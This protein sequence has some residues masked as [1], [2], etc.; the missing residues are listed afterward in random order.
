MLFAA[1]AAAADHLGRVTFGGL[2]V[3]GATV[4]ATQRDQQLTTVTDEDGVFRLIAVADGV[5]T[6]RVQMLGFAGAAQDITIAADT[7]ASSWELKLLPIADMTR[8]LQAAPAGPARP[9]PLQSGRGASA[10]AA[11]AAPAAPSTG[12]QRAQ[13]NASAPGAAIVNDPTTAGDAD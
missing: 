6:I 11:V 7:A 4:I 10:A 13:V 8:G 3:P 2:P 9:A 12:F 1:P 5:W